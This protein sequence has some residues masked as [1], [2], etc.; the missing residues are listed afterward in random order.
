[1]EEW[2]FGRKEW[3]KS[4][5]NM[6]GIWRKFGGNLEEMWKKKEKKG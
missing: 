1:M 6:E 3:K 5:R 2:G 4:G